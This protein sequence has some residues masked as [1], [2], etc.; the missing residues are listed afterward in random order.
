MKKILAKILFLTVAFTFMCSCEDETSQDVSKIT[1]YA[2][3]ELKGDKV[4]F[5][6]LNEEFVEPGYTAEM[7]GED[8]TDMVDIN[9]SV[10]V[11][12]AGI[13]E[14]NYS[15]T[16]EDGF[17][18]SQT[19]TVMVADPTPSVI[20]SGYWCNTPESSCSNSSS[21]ATYGKPYSIIILQLEPGVFYISDFLSGWY[22]QR[23]GYGSAYAMVGKFKLESDNTITALESS[24]AGWGD[25]M[26]ALTDGKYDSNT[27]KIQYKIGYAGVLNFNIELVK[28]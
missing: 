26:D 23:A 10:D 4:L 5:W 17:K 21:S 3:L 22:E 13:Y 18:T 14:L 7:K 11:T 16:N 20:T 19:R 24:V 9:G 8:V 6:D 27:G 15:V 2:T 25:S 28:E 1:Y 12:K